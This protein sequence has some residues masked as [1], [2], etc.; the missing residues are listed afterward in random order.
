MLFLRQ[1]RAVISSTATKKEP[2]FPFLFQFS[3]EN[4]K[5]LSR[6]VHSRL[7]ILLCAAL[8]R[9]D[10][11]AVVAERDKLK[12]LLKIVTD[13]LEDCVKAEYPPHLLE[14]PHNRQK[15]QND[16]EPVKAARAVL[17]EAP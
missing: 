7:Q 17:G 14:Y 9:F 6:M 13:C 12:S 8:Q 2:Y 11:Q 5:L 1:K 10:H 3:P 4:E 15:F 16:M